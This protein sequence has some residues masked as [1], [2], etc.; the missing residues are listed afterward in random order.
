LYGM[1]I[2]SDNPESVLDD[3]EAGALESI[4]YVKSLDANPEHP[5]KLRY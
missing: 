4:E 1:G 3:T 2:D 5:L